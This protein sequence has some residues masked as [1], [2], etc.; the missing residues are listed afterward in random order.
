MAQPRISRI[1]LSLVPPAT[2]GGAGRIVV[3]VEAAGG[4]VGWAACGDHGDRW[5]NLERLA[6]AV[7]GTTP[8]D[9]TR[10]H[11]ALGL[12]G[13]PLNLQRG[14]LGGAGALDN[15]VL[16]LAARLAGVPL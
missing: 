7:V 6:R 15:A 12:A 5:A 3:A 1:A 9:T 2:P 4:P 14:D 16:D 10:R 11:Q 13:E 8:S